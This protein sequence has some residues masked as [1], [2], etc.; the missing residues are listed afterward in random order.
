M[1]M[2]LTPPSV[3]ALKTTSTP[4]SAPSRHFRLT[5]HCSC[6]GN[7][8]SCISVI[9]GFGWLT[10]TRCSPATLLESLKLMQ[11]HL[12]V[13]G[14]MAHLLSDSGMVFFCPNIHVPE[15]SRLNSI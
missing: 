4:A 10:E 12:N 15:P 8:T 14:L 9:R 3:V 2:A 11:P 6:H 1:T 5:A 7:P 13:S